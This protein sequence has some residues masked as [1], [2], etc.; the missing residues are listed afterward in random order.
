[1]ARQ[2]LLFL[3]LVMATMLT[4]SNSQRG[5]KT[6]STPGGSRR[7]ERCIFPFRFDGKSGFGFSSEMKYYLT[8]NNTLRSQFLSGRLCESHV[9]PTLAAASFNRHQRDILEKYL[10]C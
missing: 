9:R 1:M 8:S 5:C 4:V 3:P 2:N 10:F 6:V 7:A